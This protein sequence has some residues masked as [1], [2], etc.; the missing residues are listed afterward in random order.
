[1]ILGKSSQYIAKYRSRSL[2][3]E[4]NPREKQDPFVSIPEI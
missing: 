3:D 4:N 2:T 1:M